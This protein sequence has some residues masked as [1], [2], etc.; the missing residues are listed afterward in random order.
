ME[1][2]FKKRAFRSCGSYCVVL[3]KRALELNGVDPNREIAFTL[4]QEPAP[5]PTE[6][7]HEQPAISEQH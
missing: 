7:K 6:E 5:E 1:I 4:S 3:P 2:K